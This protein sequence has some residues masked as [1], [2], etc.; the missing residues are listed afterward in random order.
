VLQQ[1]VCCPVIQALSYP[2]TTR[3]HAGRLKQT[4][5]KAFKTKGVKSLLKL[6]FLTSVGLY[7]RV[8]C[9]GNIVFIFF[10]VRKKHQAS[11]DASTS[12]SL[13]RSSTYVF[14]YV[15]LFTILQLQWRLKNCCLR[16]S[17]VFLLRFK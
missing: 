3:S 15:R 16:L 4:P 1:L 8:S 14:S 7:W 2:A 11:S 17:T 5:K 10:T 13:D 6:Y 12:A 9:N